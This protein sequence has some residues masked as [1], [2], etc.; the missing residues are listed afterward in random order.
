MEIVNGWTRLL[1]ITADNRRL[2]L[3]GTL[4]ALWP[5]CMSAYPILVVGL[6]EL[7][8]GQAGLSALC[9]GRVS[10]DELI[11]V[12]RHNLGVLLGGM[13]VVH[14]LA[15]ITL[16]GRFYRISGTNPLYAL[17]HLPAVLATGYLAVLA[18]MRMHTRQMTWRG[19]SYQPSADGQAGRAL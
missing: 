3:V 19:T 5:L 17:G 18:L 14:L 1:R 4:L 16:F 8:R 7:I 9:H 15:Q 10:L 13:A 6:T 2:L 12:K 11:E